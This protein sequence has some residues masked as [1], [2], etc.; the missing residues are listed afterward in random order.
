[1]IPNIPNAS[2]RSIL[3]HSCDVLELNIYKASSHEGE[4]SIAVAPVHDQLGKGTRKY[5][6]SV[7]DQDSCLDLCA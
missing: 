4:P 5:L 6:A 1:M 2:A 3:E 7:R